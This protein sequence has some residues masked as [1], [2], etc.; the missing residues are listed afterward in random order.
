MGLHFMTARNYLKHYCP[1]NALRKF[2]CLGFTDGLWLT[3][4]RFWNLKTRVAAM[5]KFDLTTKFKQHK[6]SVEIFNCDVTLPEYAWFSLHNKGKFVEQHN[7]SL[8]QAVK[9]LKSHL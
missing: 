2:R 1:N 8:K 5:L 3:Q 4:Q 7:L 9:L 6:Y